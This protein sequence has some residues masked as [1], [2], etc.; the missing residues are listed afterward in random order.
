MPFHL[1]LFWVGE[2]LD[3]TAAASAEEGAGG[4][5]PVRGGAQHFNQFGS[6]VA[7]FLFDKAGFDPF[8]GER[9]GDEDGKAVIKADPFAAVAEGVDV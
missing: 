3:L 7:L 2:V 1:E 4:L 8:R 5:Y 9:V 6:S